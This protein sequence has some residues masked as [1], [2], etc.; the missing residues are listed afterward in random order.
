[1]FILFFLLYFNIDEIDISMNLNKYIHT[2]LYL[3]YSKNQ[4]GNF[5]D[6]ILKNISIVRVIRRESLVG[7]YW[8]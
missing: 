1:M 5:K 4:V 3:K 8:S 7:E 6:Q 2:F